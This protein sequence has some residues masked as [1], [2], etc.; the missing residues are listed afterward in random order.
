MLVIYYKMWLYRQLANEMELQDK[1]LFKTIVLCKGVKLEIG[2]NFGSKAA[3]MVNRIKTF[4]F[5]T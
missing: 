5:K 4:G 1:I 3:Y 2:N